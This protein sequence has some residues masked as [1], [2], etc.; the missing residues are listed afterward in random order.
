MTLYDK[1]GGAGTIKSLVDNFYGRVLSDETLAQYFQS[2]DLA[3][4]K[5]HQALFISQALGGPKEYDGRDMAKAH[6]GLNISGADFDKVA[7]HLVG[8]MQELGVE[9][10]DIAT[11]VSVVAPLKVDVVSA[12]KRQAAPASGTPPA[13]TSATVA[14]TDGHGAPQTAAPAAAAQKAP[15]TTVA[16]PAQKAP[17]AG[18]RSKGSLYEKLGGGKTVKAVV[19]EFYQRIMAD[20]ALI[21]VFEGIDMGSLKRHQAL[22]LSQALGGPKAY[23]GRD[24]FQAHKAYLITDA[25]FDSVAGHLVGTLNHFGVAQQDIDTVV[26]VV[27][28]LRRHIVMDHF[29]RWLRGG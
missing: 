22:F 17:P 27:A 29:K 16:P 21:P 3:H 18:G 15:P 24:M 7:G 2:T 20:Q 14:A 19:E 4:L 9:E 11:V 26:S 1:Y 23:D 12:G 28:P 5:R 13:G 25:Q 8:A 10:Q 6:A